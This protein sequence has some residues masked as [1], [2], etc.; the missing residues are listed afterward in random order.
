MKL[1]RRRAVVSLA[2]VEGGSSRRDLGVF[3]VFRSFR[4]NEL[5]PSPPAPPRL[6]PRLPLHVAE[7][8]L[9]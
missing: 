5:F 8:D 1:P 4:A 7:A 2:D 6:A 9:F 3:P